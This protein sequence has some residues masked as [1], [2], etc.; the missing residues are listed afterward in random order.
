MHYA[1]SPWPKA[2]FTNSS[3]YLIFLEKRR[4]A[5]T[6]FC[7]DYLLLYFVNLFQ[8]KKKRSRRDKN[9][10]LRVKHLLFQLFVFN[11]ITCSMLNINDTSGNILS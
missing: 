5:V 8:T 7:P 3:L 10:M 6:A 1:L 2:V 11:Y 4:Y 9:V